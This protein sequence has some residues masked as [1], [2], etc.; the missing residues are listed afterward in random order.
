MSLSVNPYPNVHF[1]NKQLPK[2]NRILNFISDQMGH[3]VYQGGII[4]ES[5]HIKPSSSITEFI[6]RKLF[7]DFV[8]NAA[9]NLNGIKITAKRQCLNILSWATDG[10]RALDK[11]GSNKKARTL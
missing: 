1:G 6:M 9:N 2:S 11:I 10:L 8:E 5:E 7:F 4:A 3:I